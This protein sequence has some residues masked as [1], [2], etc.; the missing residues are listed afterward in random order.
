MKL[1]TMYMPCTSCSELAKLALDRKHLRTFSFQSIL[2][3]TFLGSQTL[4]T[5]EGK[6]IKKS[7]EKQSKGQMAWRGS[8]WN[9]WCPQNPHIQGLPL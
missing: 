3:R 2:V 9:T 5:G 4:V 1:I 6:Y 8:W 7:S